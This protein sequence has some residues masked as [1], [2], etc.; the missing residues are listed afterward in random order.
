M[1]PIPAAIPDIRFNSD[2]FHNVI[3][4][5]TRSTCKVHIQELKTTY[6]CAICGLKMCPEPCFL[7]YHTLQDNY[8][9]HNHYSGPR[10]LKRREA[11]SK[12]EE[13]STAKFNIVL[14][15]VMMWLSKAC[16]IVMG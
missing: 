2:H 10:R 11:I 9:D 5:G 15:S 3:S 4:H 8:F 1:Y 16:K 7:R 12:G 14:G 6:T 13:E